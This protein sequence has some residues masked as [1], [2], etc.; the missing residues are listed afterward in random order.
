LLSAEFQQFIARNFYLRLRKINN[1]PRTPN[2]AV[3]GSGMASAIS[4]M[5]LPPVKL[6]L[7][8]EFAT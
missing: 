3:F 1:T 6:G 5:S 8:P 2:K 4:A 7:P